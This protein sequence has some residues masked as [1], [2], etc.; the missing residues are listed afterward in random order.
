MKIIILPMDNRPP[1]YRFLIDL[2]NIYKLDVTLPPKNILG[3]YRTPGDINLL[4]EWLLRQRA[5]LYIISTDMLCYGGLIASRENWTTFEE[6]EERLSVLKI[7][8]KLNPNS[9]IQL[10]SIIRRASTSVFSESSYECWEKMNTYLRIFKT[11]PEQA[12]KVEKNFP[13]GYI[14]NYW[15]SRERNHKINLKC[16]ELVKKGI[17]DLIV[18]SVED[19]FP[20]GPHERE[21]EALKQ[22]ITEYG[23]EDKCFIH[24]GADEALQN[25]LIRTFN[26]GTINVIYDSEETKVKIMDYEDRKFLEN[27]NSHLRLTGFNV[28]ENAENVVL[29]SGNSKER[30]LKI[31]EKLKKTGKRI[32]ILDVF[33]ANGSNPDFVNDALAIGGSS[34]KGY[35]AWNTA[36]N[37]LGTILAEIAEA[38]NKDKIGLFKFYLERLLDDHLYQG[39]WRKW[40]ERELMKNGENIYDVSEKS[41]TYRRFVD[42][43]FKPCCNKFLEKYFN[44]NICVC[45]QKSC[46]F[47]IHKIELKDFKLPWN[48]TFECELQVELNGEYKH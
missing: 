15:K 28:S 3:F 10:S 43:L 14:E 38:P 17:I 27:V 45:K 7:I 31:I 20:G 22:K 6:A 16:L 44:E 39:V 48:R 21:E 36:S 2:A 11:N 13:R 24:N 37:S 5:D 4:I 12:K 47:V 8:K 1:N 41:K 19:T 46:I 18:F 30:S 35:S 25:L 9:N 40:L 42:E 29:I 33:K 23:I 26:K 32:Y 34:I